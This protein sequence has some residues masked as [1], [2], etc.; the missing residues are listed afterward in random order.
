MDLSRRIVPRAVA[1]AVAAALAATLAAPA[2]AQRADASEPA[3]ALRLARE[4]APVL[5]AAKPAAPGSSV[6]PQRP[7][8]GAEDDA[9]RGAL[10][11]RADRLEGRADRQ[12]SAEGR[13]ELRTHRETVLA[14]RIAYDLVRDEVHATGNVVLRKG[15]DWIIGP[16]VVYHRPTQSG[17]FDSPTFQ[18]GDSGARGDASKIVF[19]GADR[20][21]V[22]DGRYTTCVA[23]RDD[24][25][26]ET[27]ALELDTGRQVGTARDATVR[28]FGAPIFYS[29][30]VDF[31]LSN[32][33]KSG[34]LVPTAGSSGARGVELSLPYYFNL[35]PNYDA[36]VTPRF[37]S[38]RGLQLGGQFRYLF[39]SDLWQNGGEADVQYLPNDR[40]TGEDRYAFVWRHQQQ[41][42]V[43]G[44][45][46]YVDLN[47]VSDDKYFA[48]LADRIAI[49]SQ[50]TLP[51]EAGVSY[52]N[53]PWSLLARVQSFQTLQDPNAPI[54]PPYNRLP[55]VIGTLAETDWAGLTFSGFGEYSR[56]RSDTLTE[57]SRA[58][59]YPQV[60][61]KRGTPGWFFAARTGVHLRRYD[62]DRSAG[63]DGSPSLAVPITSVDAGLVF[64]RDWSLFGTTFT[65]TLEPRAYYVYIPYRE[66]NSLPAF[67]S[68]ID[69]Y[70]FGQLFTE[71]R[72][73]GNDRIGDANQLTIGV[74]SRLLQPGT[75]AERLRVALAQRFYFEDQRVTLN[76]VP[77]SASSSDILLAVEGR[78]SDAWTVAGLVQQNLD[79]GQNERFNV[80]AR[81]T[82]SPGRALFASYRYTRQLVN[83]TGEGSEIQQIDL[84][85]QW[86][87]NAQWTLLGRYNY[88][89]VDSKVLEAVAGV[90]YNGDCW[91]LR[92]VLHRLATTVDQTNTSFF[93]Q[94]E[95]NGL[96]RVGTS[97]LDL[98][99][100]SVPGYVSANDPSLRQRDRSGDP[101]PEF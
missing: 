36:T 65:H 44:L 70:N 18:I 60:A 90:E 80:A 1:A 5:P 82:P 33:R 54:V 8:I 89:I 13:V 37:M 41:L 39:G 74:T 43:P 40:Q 96:A 10:F 51:R 26:L 84:A 71:N 31:P 20:Y 15:N 9:E 28:F 83:P 101:L 45:G 6:R 76:E 100:R 3:L 2:C 55:Q 91:T 50:T 75:G 79:S 32:E 73:L 42:G 88:S 62:L 59:L 35:A 93:I 81:Y 97:P 46:A 48:D 68:A 61:F 14:D 86:P 16:E 57:G 34:F 72:Y 25:Y 27:R 85:A 21:E 7:S 92:A 77:R 19:A 4:L 47:K 11:L 99:R 22:T 94:L 38:K 67:D 95:L 87:V 30:W 56:F 69:D 66:Q 98:L 23:P 58:V 52:V 17:V 29:P 63:D 24:W 49:T 64:E 12:V 78:I 53:G